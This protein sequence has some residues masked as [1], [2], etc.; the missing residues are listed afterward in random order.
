MTDGSA[1]TD[2]RTEQVSA[3]ISR[4]PAGVSAEELA[5]WQ[6]RLADSAQRAEGFRRLEKHPPDATLQP[7]WSCV[8]AFDGRDALRAWLTDAAE[9]VGDDVRVLAGSQRE[10][11]ATFAIVQRVRPE[12]V[13]DYLAWQKRITSAVQRQPGFLSA[14]VV[15]TRSGD[16]PE[17][18]VINR[19]E[20]H[21]DLD[22]WV[23]SAERDALMR[24]SDGMFVDVS[25]RVVSDPGFGA[26][27]GG[28]ERI[29]TWKQNWLVLVVLYPVIVAEL[30]FL[31]PYL[32]WLNHAV[33]IFIG[34]GVSVAALGWPLV[35]LATR[36]LGWW[37]SPEPGA[38][39]RTEVLGIAVLIAT[40]A[41][42]IAAMA[43]L[44]DWVSLPG[45]DRL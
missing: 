14:E 43:L 27:F 36:A 44:M 9:L 8:V 34:A 15:R 39:R 17:W 13:D 12:R 45:I 33:A 28:A 20:T 35:G 6:D 10:E 42:L 32:G 23:R 24:E 41:V 40:C 3:V 30:V 38:G 26:W 2:I 19:F 11:L 37:A 5:A 31:D 18:T 29:P 16:V 4:D 1:A 21:D 22:A 25:R 7:L